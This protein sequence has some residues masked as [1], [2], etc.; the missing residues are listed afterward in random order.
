[1]RDRP[2]PGGTA[3]ASAPVTFAGIATAIGM[4]PPSR[5]KPLTPASLT[6]E[7][8]QVADRP[9]STSPLAIVEDLRSADT[10]AG[11]TGPVP[12]IAR[13]R[14][15]RTY[16]QAMPRR[17]LRGDRSHPARGRS[18]RYPCP[19]PYGPP[20]D[21]PGFVESHV[22]AP[23]HHLRPH[24]RDPQRVFAWTGT[25]G[26]AQDRSAWK[27]SGARPSGVTRRPD[28]RSNAS[29]RPAWWSPARSSSRGSAR[30]PRTCW[31]RRATGRLENCPGLA[32]EAHL[33][34][35][36]ALFVPDHVVPP[37]AIDAAR[38]WMLTADQG[39][40]LRESGDLSLG[41]WIQVVQAYADLQRRVTPH[42]ED[43]EAALPALEPADAREYLA[44]RIPVLAALAAD[45][46]RHLD[47][48]RAAALEADLDEI[49]E[50]G[51]RLAAG[52]VPVSFDHSDLHDNNVFW[53]PPQARFFDLGDALLAHPFSSLL[54]A[55]RVRGMHDWDAPWRDDIPR[56]RDAYLEV[57][58]DLGSHAELVDLVE[59]SLACSTGETSPDP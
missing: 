44:G 29:R 32:F 53:H 16:D 50:L 51:E 31:C 57:W 43:L 49:G 20:A 27:R 55:C 4:I 46:P 8:D 56:I 1:M 22:C 41:T 14:I 30:G 58:S 38:G 9:A 17:R 40:T 42:A 45:G 52:P 35:A 23:E 12:S 13:S 18:G 7:P 10:L 6:C 28:G 19:P 24:K 34:A 25:G 11:F 48:D 3:G 5:D 59:Q 54:V 36:L 2:R 15:S 47:A 33:V 37:L 21:A 39:V 26:V